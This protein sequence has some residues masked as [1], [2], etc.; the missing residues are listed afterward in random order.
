[1]EDCEEV[2]ICVIT[3]NESHGQ[4]RT[5]IVKETEIS[6]M[7][8]ISSIN[9]SKLRNYIVCKKNFFPNSLSCLDN[10]ISVF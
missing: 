7:D 8:E 10:K 3:L 9:L 6:N 1:M 5:K 2:R 4:H